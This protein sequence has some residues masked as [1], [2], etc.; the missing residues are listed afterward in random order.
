MKDANRPK[1]EVLARPERRRYTA[2]YKA[3]VL[4]EA[5]AAQGAGAINALLRREGLYS[6]ILSKW[7]AQ[8]DRGGLAG[9][10]SRPPGP[11]PATADEVEAAR[12]RRENRELKS[13]LDRANKIIEVQKNLRRSWGSIFSDRRTGATGEPGPRAR[14]HA[15]RGAA[16]RRARAAARHLLPGD[17]TGVADA[18]NAAPTPITAANPATRRARRRARHPA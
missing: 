18:Q 7:R 1:T 13:K 9:L 3:R 15:R 16:V 5:D 6:S 12:L 4:A 14:P 17:P 11:K 8:R 10:E 2:E